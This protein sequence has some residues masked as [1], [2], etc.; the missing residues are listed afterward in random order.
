[1]LTHFSAVTLFKVNKMP[2]VQIDNVGSV[3]LISD[4]PSRELPPEAW[5]D[6]LNVRFSNQNAEKFYGHIESF[7]TP[8][9][10][11]QYLLSAK[12]DG[13]TYWYYANGTA[14]Y[15]SDGTTE[16]DVTRTAGAYNGGTYSQWNGGILG[17][18]P[19]MNNTSGADYP[20][21]WDAG[22]SKMKDLDNWPADTYTK[23]IRPFK[24]ALVALN[25]TKSGTNY[26]Y[27]VKVS[28]PADPGTVPT[29]WDETDATKLTIE[30]PLSEGSDVIVD[31]LGLGDSFI[32]Y[33]ERSTWIMQFVGGKYVYKTRRL[34]DSF[35]MLTQNCA[36]NTPKGQFVVARGDVILHNGTT[37]K[38]IIDEQTRDLLF[39][40]I[41]DN[42][43]SYIFVVINQQFNEVW[44]C[45]AEQGRDAPYANKAMIWN[46]ISGVWSQRDLPEIAFA[47]SG[48]I[49][50][51]YA[52]K[53]F[54]GS[55]GT[56]FD[57]DTGF[58][59]QVDYPASKDRILMCGAADTKFYLAD[60]TNQFA[61]SNFTSYLERTGLG[62]VGRDRFGNWKVDLQSVKLVRNIYPKITADSGT[63]L[64][65]YVGI[66]L[67]QND[68]IDWQGPFEFNPATDTKIDCIV[69]T[70]LLCLRFE[71]SS[72][73]WWKM[74]GYGVDLDIIGR[75]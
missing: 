70:K 45:Y 30:R 56:T 33:K 71:T 64:K 35:G 74:H 57:A 19:I 49:P 41:D 48:L 25:I 17:G 9:I 15:R 3:G 66:Q 60:K 63:I 14:I 20:Q 1:V 65:I 68:A 44:I 54:D 73:A 72:N 13:T 22:A 58:F 61:G 31:G 23:V 26:P 47:A 39:N 5:S 34:F 69:A 10:V 6:C 53:T 36:V 43:S 4:Q 37:Y 51:S 46:W 59:N 16:S 29:S 12:F 42:Y 27:T 7:D 11:P 8:S 67:K 2:I 40:S 50:A 28:H 32:I 24:Q 21:Q 38:S 18:V 52:D 62:V 55:V 75:Y